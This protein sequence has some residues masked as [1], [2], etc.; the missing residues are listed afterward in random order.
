MRAR[1]ISGSGVWND[2]GSAV[3]R[4]ARAARCTASGKSGSFH[5]PI[6]GRQRSKRFSIRRSSCLT[7]SA[8]MGNFKRK[9][10]AAR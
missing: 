8:L 6:A 9:K 2:P 1:T 7:K 10:A 5:P 3:H 4:S